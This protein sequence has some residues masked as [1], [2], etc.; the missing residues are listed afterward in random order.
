MRYCTLLYLLLIFSVAETANSEE[1]P[2][3]LLEGAKWGD[4]LVKSGCG[5]IT[6]TWASVDSTSDFFKRDMNKHKFQ[7]V[8]IQNSPK[9][10]SIFYAFDGVYKRY[11]QHYSNVIGSKT[12]FDDEAVFDGEKWTEWYKTLD[13]TAEVKDSYYV[14]TSFPAVYNKAHDP[15][16]YGLKIQDTN[17]SDFL[18]GKPLN[19]GRKLI[20]KPQ[21]IGEE[22]VDDSIC[23]MVSA[24][25][26]GEDGTITVWLSH[27]QMF[28]PLK[29]EIF[30]RHEKYNNKTVMTNKFN[31][32]KNGCWFPKHCIKDYYRFHHE[33]KEWIWT[34]TSSITVQDDFKINCYITDD[35]F[36]MPISK[37]A[38]VVD[39]IMGVLSD[40]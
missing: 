11:N 31:K 24:Q 34:T 32:H 23:S 20:D 12:I 25:L 38:T 13:A 16:R 28:R 40:K 9:N 2:E 5:T 18:L 7:N 36:K 6:Y 19:K 8:T 17:V 15:L 3:Y 4:S 35:I 39:R 30:T 33:N 37:N 22:I 26:V 10:L 21:Y 1:L 29:I 27:E 14:I